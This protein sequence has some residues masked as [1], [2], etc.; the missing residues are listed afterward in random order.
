MAININDYKNN[1]KALAFKNQLDYYRNALNGQDL[2]LG[3]NEINELG[4]IAYVG[5][6]GVILE[7]RDFLDDNADMVTTY[8]Y[9]ENGIFT[10]ASKLVKGSMV[11][12]FSGFQI[13][14]D[15]SVYRLERNMAKDVYRD[16]FDK[17]TLLNNACVNE[18]YIAENPMLTDNNYSS[19]L[20]D[21]GYVE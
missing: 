14:E 21:F 4:D 2:Q 12:L 1:P 7:Q 6:N 19:L 15:G 20:K 8:S 17:S 3:A 11:Q 5:G 13:A 9:E 10:S 18:D 16:F